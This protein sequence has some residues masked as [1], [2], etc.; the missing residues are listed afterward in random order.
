MWYQCEKL[1]RY[2]RK[3]I[4]CVYLE[5]NSIIIQVKNL[6]IHKDATVKKSTTL[7]TYDA[8][9]VDKQRGNKVLMMTAISEMSKRKKSRPQKTTAALIFNSDSELSLPSATSREEKVLPK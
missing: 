4:Y 6:W 5:K 2:N 9:N 3:T 7:P 8:I 1:V